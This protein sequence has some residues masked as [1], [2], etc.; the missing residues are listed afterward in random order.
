MLDNFEHLALR[1]AAGGR[2]CW[3]P[4]LNLRVLVTS[5]LALR[6][7]GEQQ[8]PVPPLALPPIACLATDP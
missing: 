3:L 1:S 7:R 2:T 8:Y 6:L 4:A 5:R